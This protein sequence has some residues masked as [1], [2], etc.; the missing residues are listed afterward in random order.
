MRLLPACSSDKIKGEGTSGEGRVLVE[1]VQDAVSDLV[2]LIKT[3]ES[4]NKM[5]QVFGSALFK[6]RLKEADATIDRAI[7]RLQVSERRCRL[8]CVVLIARICF[9]AC[10]AVDGKKNGDTSSLSTARGSRARF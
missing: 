10:A 4:K 9:R 2:E 1:D 8:L 7:I 5:T 3:Y 6:K